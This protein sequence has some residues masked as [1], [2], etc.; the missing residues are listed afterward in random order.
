MRFNEFKTSLSTA[1]TLSPGEE[2]VLPDFVIVKKGNSLSKIADKFRIPLSDLIAANP[3]IMNPD[4]IHP[5]DKIKLPKKT[6]AVPVSPE[7]A[8]GHPTMKDDPRIVKPDTDKPAIIPPGASTAGAGQG[9]RGMSMSGGKGP[10]KIGNVANAKIIFDHFKSDGFNDIQAAAF[11]GNFC[12]E[13]Q[14][15]PEAAG[16]PHKVTKKKQ[17]H[18][19][20]QWR[21]ERL[22][23]LKDMFGD[24]WNTL[25][26]QLKWA[27]FELTH[28]PKFI[29]VRKALHSVP[30]NL[31]KCVEIIQHTFEIADPAQAKYENRLGFARTALELFGTKK[32]TKP[33]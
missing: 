24:K 29:R 20:A 28:V 13:S 16:D 8:R 3:E 18:G 10:Y 14:L 19:I 27:T 26:N 30:D 6:P 22:D 7:I 4:V 23:K 21:D 11:V 1:D 33:A 17:S 2:L 9:N 31:E 15:D 32:P 12:Q 5:G 25:S